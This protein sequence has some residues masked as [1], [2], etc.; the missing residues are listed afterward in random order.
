MLQLWRK[1]MVCGE[2]GCSQGGSTGGLGGLNEKSPGPKLERSAKLSFVFFPESYGKMELEAGVVW[3][4]LRWPDSS[5]NMR[6]SF[7]TAHPQLC[8]HHSGIPYD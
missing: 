6:T 3:A 2:E 7:R 5:I 4:Y 1:G 8:N